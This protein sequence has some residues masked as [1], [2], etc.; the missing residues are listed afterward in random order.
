MWGE[1]RGSS[2]G[3]AEQ[4]IMLNFSSTEKE[5]AVLLRSGDIERG[6]RVG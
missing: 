6:A 1:N 4:C 3:Q 2:I 5:T